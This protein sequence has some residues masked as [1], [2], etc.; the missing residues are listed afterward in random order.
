MEPLCD[1]IVVHDTEPVL[2]MLHWHIYN[3]RGV[4]PLTQQLGWQTAAADKS[5]NVTIIYMK[6][7]KLANID[8]LLEAKQPD[9]FYMQRKGDDRRWPWYELWPWNSDFYKGDAHLKT[10]PCPLFGWAQTSL[11]GV[12]TQGDQINKIVPQW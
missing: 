6:T 1:I 2:K 7:L 12:V 5:V 8:C 4:V 3:S 10:G 11:V 9:D